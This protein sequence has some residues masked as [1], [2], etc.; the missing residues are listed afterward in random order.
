MKE[1]FIVILTTA[2]SAAE[3]RRIS[4]ALLKSRAAACVNII[5]KITSRYWW[6]GKIETGKELLLVIKTRQSLYRKVEKII[7]E[8]HS[9]KTPEVITISIERGSADYLRW[10]LD[11][12]S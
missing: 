6:K 3:A 2:S 12:T 1:K 9:Y 5:P 4:G 11:E 8:N 10:I 7:L